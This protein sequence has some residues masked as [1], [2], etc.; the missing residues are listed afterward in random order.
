M[1][2]KKFLRKTLK[3]V[4][5]EFPTLFT[6]IIRPCVL[7]NVLWTLEC[8]HGEQ[9]NNPFHNKS[10]DERKACQTLMF[11]HVNLLQTFSN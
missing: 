7:L 11:T 6:L 2:S 10:K 1:I 5:S 9:V 3:I 4:Q 8:T